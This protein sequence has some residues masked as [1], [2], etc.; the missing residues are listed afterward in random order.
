M[1]LKAYDFNQSY[2]LFNVDYLVEPLRNKEKREA[3][4]SV[5]QN[6][7]GSRFYLTSWFL[8]L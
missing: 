7:P 6:T 3:I 4:L 5:L 2:F 1:K 8:T